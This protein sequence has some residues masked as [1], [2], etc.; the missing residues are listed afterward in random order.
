[1]AVVGFGFILFP[2]AFGRG[3][4]PA[5]PSP[6]LISYL[7]L[8]GSPLIGIAVLN[9]KVRKEGPS[10]ALDAIV[11]GNIVGFAVMTLL[12][13]WGLLNE[14]R[15]VTKVFV[16]VHLVF[17]LAFIIIGRKRLSKNNMV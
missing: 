17:T 7:R 8:W 1:M 3:A 2:E 16:V 13:A 15:P 4:L 12:D 6:T 5:D 10:K 9:W 14:A 11:V